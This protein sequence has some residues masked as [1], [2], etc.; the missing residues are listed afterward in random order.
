[1]VHHASAHAPSDTLEIRLHGN[2]LTAQLD[3]DHVLLLEPV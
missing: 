3:V 2:A 1:M